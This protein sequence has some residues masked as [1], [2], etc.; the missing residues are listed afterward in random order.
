[1]T[2]CSDDDLLLEYYGEPASP[3]THLARCGACAARYLEVKAFLDGLTLEPPE[4]DDRYGLEVWQRIRHRLPAR[5]SRWEQFTSVRFAFA[6]AAATVLLATGFVGGR[7]WPST[8]PDPSAPALVA[9]ARDD[10]DARRR[11]VLLT[12]AEH[13]DRSDRVLAEIM[14]APGAGDLSDEQEWAGDL[15][16]ASRLYRQNA[17]AV[18]ER[19]IAAVLEELERVLLDVVHQPSTP[20][21]ADLEQIRQRID[22]AA[23]LFKVRVLNSELQRRLEESPAAAR[24]PSTSTIG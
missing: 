24:S 14:N 15:V 11:V 13:L 22:S 18:D 20:G 21:P 17:I 2:H 12:V 3:S 4:R 16:A 5:E 7:L 8:T 19:A 9:D 10:E 1:M 23:L 6:A